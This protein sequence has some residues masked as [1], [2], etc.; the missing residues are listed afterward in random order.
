MKKI[1]CWVKRSEGKYDRVRAWQFAEP[2]LDFCAV[3]SEKYRY[4][5][6]IDVCTG[7]FIRCGLPTY[8][9]SL[10]DCCDMILKNQKLV[11]KAFEDQMATEEWTE[12]GVKLIMYIGKVERENAERNE[13]EY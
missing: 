10:R 9:K 1:Q 8:S 11:R 6:F 7:K 5:T 12:D 2:D 4:W 3:Y 13:S